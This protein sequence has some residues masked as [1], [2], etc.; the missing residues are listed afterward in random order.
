MSSWK[1]S[2]LSLLGGGTSFWIADVLIPVLNRREQGGA[3]TFACPIGLIL[4]YSAILRLRQAERSGPSTAIFALFGTWVLAIPFIL[5]A[6]KVRSQGGIGFSWDE[7][8][9]VLVSSFLPPRIVEM[10]TLEGSIIALWIGTIAM[11]ICHLVFERS[12]W[13][14]PKLWAA[15]GV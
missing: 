10:A 5:L 4:F 6:Q 14:V 9:Y 7:V 3:I 11:I 12:R 2:F 15:S 1:W 13:I 8:P